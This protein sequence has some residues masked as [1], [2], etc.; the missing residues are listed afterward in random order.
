MSSTSIIFEY[1]WGLDGSADHSNFQQKSKTNISTRQ[2][3]SC[4]FTVRE[5]RV[6]GAQGKSVRWSSNSE[7]ANKPQIT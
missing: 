3:M 7:G 6:R 2:V 4:C 5:V 1:C